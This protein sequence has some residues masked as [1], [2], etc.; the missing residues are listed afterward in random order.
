V[1]FVTVKCIVTCI[2][3]SAQQESV[4]IEW[5][6][7]HTWHA[8]PNALNSQW[9]QY[10]WADSTVY[11]P[12]Q[13]RIVSVFWQLQQHRC[14]AWCVTPM[15]FVNAGHLQIMQTPANKCAVI[16]AAEW[17]LWR[18]SHDIAQ[19]LGVPQMRF[20]RVLLCSWIRTTTGRMRVCFQ[21][22]VH[23]C[24]ICNYRAVVAGSCEGLVLVSD[25][26]YLEN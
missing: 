8:L 25:D 18:S 17:E 15:V 3:D 7:I 21:T 20:L 23:A 12:G 10:V 4:V 5:S 22:L 11:Y 19:E 26:M 13:H 24:C 6:W 1:L 14:E 2:E 16:A 9:L